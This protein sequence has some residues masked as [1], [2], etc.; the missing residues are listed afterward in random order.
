MRSCVTRL[1]ITHLSIKIDLLIK[2]NNFTAKNKNT[3]ILQDDFRVK[4]SK[5]LL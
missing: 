1:T 2:E 4:E 3:S 5:K